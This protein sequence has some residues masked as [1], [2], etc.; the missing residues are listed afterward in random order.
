MRPRRACFGL[1]AQCADP[2]LAG[3]ALAAAYYNFCR[4]HFSLRVAIGGGRYRQ[5]TPAIALGVTGHQW[6]VKEF[7][8]HPVY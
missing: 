1:T 8:T 4:P 5:R 6:T 7:I 2:T 3:G